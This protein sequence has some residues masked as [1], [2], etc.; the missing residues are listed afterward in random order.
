MD[1]LGNG[2]VSKVVLD[3]THKELKGRTGLTDSE[4]EGASGEG[5]VN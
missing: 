3:S 1:E 4:D 5:A 2:Q